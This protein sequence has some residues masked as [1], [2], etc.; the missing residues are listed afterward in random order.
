MSL[1]TFGIHC[2]HWP[3]LRKHLTLSFLDLAREFLL[4]TALLVTLVGWLGLFCIS[5]W[6]SKRSRGLVV[7]ARAGTWTMTFLGGPRH[8]HL[9]RFKVR[10]DTKYFRP[11]R[12]DTNTRVV[13][14]LESQHNGPYVTT[15]ILGRA[16][17]GTARKQ[18]IGQYVALVLLWQ[19]ILLSN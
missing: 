16:W 14:C 7:I 6:L 3:I 9:A 10:H 8:D 15:R 12:H 11:C 2:L 1:V 19:L 5:F 13:S 18:P 17:A 4:I